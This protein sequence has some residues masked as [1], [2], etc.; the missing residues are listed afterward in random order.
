[1]YVYTRTHIYREKEEERENI[2]I[3][4]GMVQIKIST[5]L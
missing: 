2:Q 1:M 5:F 4:D 3:N